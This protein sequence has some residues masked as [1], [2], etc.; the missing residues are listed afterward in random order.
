MSGFGFGNIDLFNV[1]LDDGRTCVA[2]GAATSPE[3]F[4]SATVRR[5]ASAATS[6]LGG[7]RFS[8][9]ETTFENGRLRLT[10]HLSDARALAIRQ[11][12]DATDEYGV[13]TDESFSRRLDDGRW[14]L[15]RYS[16]GDVLVHPFDECQF[17]AETLPL[18]G[19]LC[20]QLNNYMNDYS[21]TGGGI[22]ISWHD[23][24]VT[25]GGKEARSTLRVDLLA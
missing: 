13:P 17:V 10:F 14:S 21:L 7:R 20:A 22:E 4:F 5:L 16:I 1:F 15:A 23:T 6:Y 3:I 24:E 2:V 8:S 19:V 12:N 18:L 25:A 11:P 9:L